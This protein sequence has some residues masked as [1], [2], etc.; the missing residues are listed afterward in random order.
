MKYRAGLSDS[1][2]DES[3][4]EHLVGRGR[5]DIVPDHKIDMN[6]STRPSPVTSSTT[7]L[8]SIPGQVSPGPLPPVSLK[9]FWT[10]GVGIIMEE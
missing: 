4:V 6:L 5:H 3:A 2:P 9:H 10:A 8:Q 7:T 1:E